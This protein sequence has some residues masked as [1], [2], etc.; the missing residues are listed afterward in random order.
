MRSNLMRITAL[1]LILIMLFLSCISCS[2]NGN[3]NSEANSES[4]SVTDSAND[5]VTDSTNDPDNSSDDGENGNTSENIMDDP[6]KAAKIKEL[7]NIKHELRCDENGNFK[8]LVLSDVQCND[9]ALNEETKNAIKTVVDREDPDLVIFNGDNSFSIQSAEELKVYIGNMVGYIEER[10]IPWGHVFGNHDY[11]TSRCPLNKEEQQKVYES[12]DYCVSK[13]GD[14]ELFGVGNYVLPVLEHEGNKIAF[15]VWCLD[16]GDYGAGGQHNPNVTVYGN[17]FNG[18]YE[19][20]EQNQIDWY[21]ESSELLEQYNG[22]KIPSM[23]TFHIPLQESF[24]AWHLKDNLG[25]ECT[26]EK[27]ENVSANAV[28]CGLFEAART[29]GDVLAIVNSHDHRN[30]FMVKYQGIRLCYTACIGTYEYHA[31]DMLGGRVLNFNSNKPDDVET[32]MSYVNERP[33]GDADKTI[34]DL[35]IDGQG[36]TNRSEG[37]ANVVKHEYDGSY[38]NIVNDATLGKNVIQFGRDADYNNDYPSVYNM[39][40]AN[41]NY[42]FADGFAVEVVFKATGNDFINGYAGIVDFMEAGGWS[43]GL[44]RS[45]SGKAIL[46]SS[47][48]YS[49]L[50]SDVYKTLK[51]EINLNTWYHCVLV[52]DG[53]D[54]VYLYLNGELVETG[55][56]DGDYADTN[57]GSLENNN[58]L[59]NDAY[60]CIGA[61]VQPFRNNSDGKRERSTG[62]HG[63]IGYIADVNIYSD[64]ISSEEITSLYNAMKK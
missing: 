45:G 36:V 52:Y 51:H 46:S 62:K 28:N 53:K 13:A 31:D 4:D 56:L 3:E 20:M 61:C 44:M 59:Y 35:N 15:N 11:E 49:S 19:P 30:D 63:F 37:K 17:R 47:V 2:S 22:G 54:T 57:F 10:Q 25:L 34:L 29:R 23:M 7:L 58:K 6:E 16:S 42:I 12:F 5:T 24:Y 14:E 32:Y 48:A 40:A 27:R 39:A 50:G 60:I 26:G 41:Y 43:I 38:T 8:V 18:A 21:L 33:K 9:P 55:T 64:P 1:G